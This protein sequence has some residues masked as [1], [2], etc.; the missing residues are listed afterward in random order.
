MTCD[1]VRGGQQ[2]AD[3]LI[4]QGHTPRYIAGRPD[5][6]TNVERWRGFSG[7]CTRRGVLA[8]IR[9][10]AGAFSYEAGYAA[11]RRLLARM[12]R[13]DAIFGANDIVALGVVDAARREFGLKV[14]QI[15]LS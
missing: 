15:S 5:A 8:P 13:P 2:I 12:P 3:Y 10:E 9:E 1:N 6:S 14:P 7:R 11:A 4:D